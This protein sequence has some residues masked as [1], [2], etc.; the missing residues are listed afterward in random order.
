[1]EFH[2]RSSVREDLIARKKQPLSGLYLFTKLNVLKIVACLVQVLCL[3]KFKLC[4]ILGGWVATF[5][6]NTVLY[7]SHCV[8]T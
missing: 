8:K 2:S 5:N 7:S 3:K 1:M 4:Q 6:I